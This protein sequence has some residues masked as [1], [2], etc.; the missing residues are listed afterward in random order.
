MIRWLRR[1]DRCLALSYDGFLCVSTGSLWMKVSTFHLGI[2]GH[3]VH[4]CEG[5]SVCG[6][7]R[8]RECMYLY[9]F[10]RAS[11]C[12]CVCVFMSLHTN[13]CISESAYCKLS[14]NRLTTTYQTSTT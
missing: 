5:T 7:V 2:A 11:V 12:I 9:V 4:P 14:I 13:Q 3:C 6:C 8:V 1:V 10:A